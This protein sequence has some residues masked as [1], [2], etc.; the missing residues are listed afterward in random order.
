MPVY[1]AASLTAGRGG[2]AVAEVVTS[3]DGRAES[4]RVLEAP[5]ESI[6]VA[7]EAALR[8]WVWTPTRLARTGEGVRALGKVI[9]YFHPDEGTVT[10]PLDLRQAARREASGG[11]RGPDEDFRQIPRADVASLARTG[12][13]VFVDIREREQ[14]RHDPEPLEAVNIPFDELAALAFIELPHDKNIAVL[15]FDFSRTFCEAA[16]ATIAAEGV[17]P[18][19]AIVGAEER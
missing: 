13:W 18:S 16:A 12:D 2:V 14:A 9:F 19:V 11:D 7:V 17:F 15:C 6:A 3:V 1:P 5:D 10:T 4:V 8:R